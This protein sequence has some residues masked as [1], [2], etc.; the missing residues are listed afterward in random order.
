VILSLIWTEWY[1]NDSFGNV[2]QYIYLVWPVLLLC[3]LHCYFI[4]IILMVVPSHTFVKIM[5]V[6]II[7]CYSFVLGTN[8]SCWQ[9]CIEN[10]VYD[11]HPFYFT[12]AILEFWKQY[13]RIIY[14]LNFFKKLNKTITR[15]PMHNQI[16]ILYIHDMYCHES[17]N[18]HFKKNS[19]GW[20][21][22]SLLVLYCWCTSN[23]NNNNIDLCFI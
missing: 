10:S 22:H 8:L 21:A 11:L 4:V 13:N 23:N 6:T 20:V 12:A 18:C 17:T 2:E 5:W 3:S 9:M 1:L 7:V 14:F 15:L 16:Y 19:C